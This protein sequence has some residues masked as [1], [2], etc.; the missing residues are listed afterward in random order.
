MAKG[1]HNPGGRSGLLEHMSRC[2]GGGLAALVCKGPDDA[3]DDV[4]SGSLGALLPFGHSSVPVFVA[5]LAVLQYV[6]GPEQAAGEEGESKQT[7][8]SLV[9]S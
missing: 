2:L 3:F 5:V 6:H 7:P 9:Q 8:T 4:E 1:C